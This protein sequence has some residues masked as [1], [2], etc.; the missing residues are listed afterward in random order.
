[1]NFLEEKYKLSRN[2]FP[3]AA[4]GIDIERDI[5]IPR[6]WKEKIDK[7]YNELKGGVGAKA[8]PIIGEYGSGKTV[9]L[10]GYLKEFFEKN[11]IKSFYFE[12][13]GTQF[14]DLA[15]TLL[16]N[17]GR[18][19]FSKAI[20]ELAKEF[21]TQGK[22]RVLAPLSFDN[23]IAALKTKTDRENRAH[24]LSIIIREKLKITDDEEIADKIAL[25]VVETGI[26]RHFEYRDF[27]AGTK[28]SLVA[29]GEEP[30]YF[31]AIIK[32][33]F[34]IYNV[35]GVAFLIDEFEDVA[36]HKRMSRNKTYEYLATLRHLIDLSEQ[37]NL[38]IVIAMTPA[39]A[40]ETK[41]MNEAL[42]DRF[43]HDERTTL[44]LEPLETGECKELI[45]WWLNRGREEDEF[46]SFRNKIFPFSDDF[47]TLLEEN[48]N[49][50]LPRPLVKICYYAISKGVLE[51]I[52]PT[53]P[54]DFIK[55]EIIDRF[56]PLDE[57]G[58]NEWQ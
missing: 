18:Y 52:E 15:N 50:R 28:T 40:K 11:R 35:D 30:K 53:I 12:N 46:K 32:T 51:K 56:Y 22:Q 55:K 45:I 17:I 3:P 19:E 27:V 26:K 6:R 42:W 29:E 1:M 58:K 9:L 49:I 25:M 39:A 48:P 5:Y 13:P 36:L 33:I 57:G 54:S 43:T 37:I 34:K 44:K 47:I 7:Y 23:M 10:K 14:Y 4:A 31:K 21:L 16:R 38:W 24:E 41:D 8:F 2:P 20:W